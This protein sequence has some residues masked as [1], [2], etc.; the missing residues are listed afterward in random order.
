MSELAK[1]RTK[2]ASDVGI[3]QVTAH[4]ELNSTMLVP[5]KKKKKDE[6]LNREVMKMGGTDSRA[7][8]SLESQVT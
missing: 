4:H 8:W 2:L 3:S 1:L 5:K 6:G 7:T